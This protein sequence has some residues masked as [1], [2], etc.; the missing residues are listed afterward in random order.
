MTVQ[1]SIEELVLRLHVINAEHL[2]K[3]AVKDILC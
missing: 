2:Q 3:S 1:I